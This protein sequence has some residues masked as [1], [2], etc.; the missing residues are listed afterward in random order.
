MQS[1]MKH[2]KFKGIPIQDI[3]SGYLRWMAENLDDGDLCYAADTEYQRRE[4]ELDH[5]WENE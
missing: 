4:R 1:T 3:P 2:G 5:W